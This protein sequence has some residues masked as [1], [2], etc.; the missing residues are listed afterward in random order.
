V[1]DG[2]VRC[3]RG[4]TEGA[5]AIVR[6]LF[7]DWMRLLAGEITPTDSIRLGLTEIEGQVPPVTLLGRWIDRA[8]GVDGPEQAREE[9]QRAIQA[10]R[11]GV[12]GSHANGASA[13]AGDPA[14]SKR[15][16]GGLMDYEQLYALWE[17]QNWRSH[18][19][20][21]SV[22]KQHWLT[23]PSEAQQHTAF[24]L[25][26][27]Y[28]GEERVTADLAPFVLA[29]PSGEIEAFLATQLVDEMRHAVFFDR[30][31]AEVMGLEANDM[32]ARLREIEENLLTLAPWHFLF[33]DSLRGVANRI[34]AKPDDL[35]LFVEG[36]VT[37]HMV[38][39]GVLAMPGQRILIQYTDDHSLYPGFNKGFRLVEQD[40]HRHIAFGVRFLKDVCEERP[41][42]RQVIL[43]TLEKLLPEAAKVFVPPEADDPAD[44]V[45]YGHH[46]SQ[47]Y[48]FAYQALKRR[49]SMIGV[50]IAPPER[51]MPGPVDFGGLDEL[52]PLAEQAAAAAA[53]A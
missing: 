18:E 50:E 17:R 5:D 34:K 9:R 3:E 38:T 24:S 45:S 49:M 6:V 41:E 32:R 25:G 16:R 46:S 42:M 53:P 51:L 23:T 36:I 29:A 39:E 26:S 21:F 47:V 40:E 19:L 28:V 7:S 11:A 12:W 31:M 2:A 43:D 27:F 44:F 14:E 35:E 20:D 10:K 22:D 1:D 4:L 48:G 13:D 8:E 52:R 37:Y 30:W 15:P 33:D